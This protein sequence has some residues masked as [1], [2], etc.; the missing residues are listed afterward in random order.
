MDAKKLLQLPSRTD[1]V[2][3]VMQEFTGAKNTNQL[4]RDLEISPHERSHFNE[5]HGR[6]AAQSARNMGGI[7]FLN[8]NATYEVGVLNREFA[9]YLNLIGFRKT[10]P[11]SNYKGQP[12]EKMHWDFTDP[13]TDPRARAQDPR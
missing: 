9:G 10:Q 4:V 12:E 8:E 2:G 1:F 11:Y 7:D 3:V 5:A 13:I 6:F